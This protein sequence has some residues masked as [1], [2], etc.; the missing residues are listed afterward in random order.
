M[1]MFVGRRHSEKH[2]Y[3]PVEIGAVL[4]EARADTWGSQVV[5]GGEREW[6][7]FKAEIRA[8]IGRIGVH[9]RVVRLRPMKRT[10][11]SCSSKGRQTFDTGLLLKPARFRAEAVTP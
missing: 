7:V 6:A 3:P 1:K 8:W 2:R 4:T 11:A 10:W 5:R 9:P